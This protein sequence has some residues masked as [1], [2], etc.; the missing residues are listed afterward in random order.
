MGRSLLGRQTP[1]HLLNV[2]SPVSAER[3]LRTVASCKRGRGSLVTPRRMLGVKQKTPHVVFEALHPDDVLSAVNAQS[4][5]RWRSAVLLKP[6]GIG[7]QLLLDWAVADIDQARAAT[8]QDQRRHAT[9]AVLNARRALSCLVDEFLFRDAFNFCK[10]AP[11]DAERRADLLLRRGIVDVLANE[12]LRRAVE[13]RNL[14]EHKYQSLTLGEAEDTVQLVRAS[15]GAALA[16]H[17]PYEGTSLVGTILG[18]HGGEVDRPDFWFSG[19]SGIAF[20]VV[21]ETN[22]PWFGVVVPT[23]EEDAVVRRVELA[24]LTCDV[25]LEVLSA[26][27]AR[28]SLTSTE[29]PN[30][31]LGTLRAASLLE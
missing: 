30:L 7:H 14:V 29:S 9:N 4:L 18:G 20:V 31:W 6:Q 1:A 16:S 19:W 8:G 28:S 12:A 15:I 23:N 17:R 2:P 22:P 25:W 3:R 13:R 11:G 21:R 24:S 10:D 27:E 26:L 5:P